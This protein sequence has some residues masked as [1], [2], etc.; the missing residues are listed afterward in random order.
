MGGMKFATQISPILNLFIIYYCHNYLFV[1]T[2]IYLLSQL[3]ISFATIYLLSK[4]LLFQSY[5]K[6]LNDNIRLTNNQDKYID[7]K[8]RHKK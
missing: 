5:L 8:I 6:C 7:H 2:T 4:L 3:L 1:V